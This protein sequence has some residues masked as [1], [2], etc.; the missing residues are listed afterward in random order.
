MTANEELPW[1]LT[2]PERVFSTL[3]RPNRYLALDF[4]TT[5]IDKGSA[6]NEL[7]DIVLACWAIVES[8]GTV[9]RKHIFGDQYSLRELEEDIR[10]T[11]FI[12]AHNA[13]FELQWLKRCGL[14]LRDV[15]VFDTMLAEWVIGGNRY[16]ISDLGLEASCL[17]YGLGTKLP[18]AGMMIK[19]G[20][21]PSTI[22]REWLLD[23]CYKDVEL[24]QMLYE[25]QREV[26]KD[27]RLFHL[28]LTRNLTCACLADI[29]FNGCELDRDKVLAEYEKA[30]EEFTKIEH[31]LADFAGDTN[32]SSSKQLAVL[33]Y[34]KLGF[35]PPLDPRTKEPIKT[36]GGKV[37]TDVA[38]L[39]KLTASTTD[40]RTFLDL[41]KRRNK[42]SALLTKTLE[43]CKGVVEEYDGKY[44][45]ILNQGFTDTHRLSSSGKPLKFKAHKKP[46]GI[47]LQ[48]FPRELKFLFT[49]HNP[50]YLIA[51]A[52]G[53]QLEFRVAAELGRDKVAY[54]EIIKGVDVHSITAKVL[55]EAGEPTT[56]QQAKAS[57][58]APLFGGMG[59]TK[60]VK[61][62]A[63]FF[64]KKYAGIAKTQKEWTLHVLNEGWLRTRFGMKFYWPG[65]R[66]GRSGYIDNTTSIYNYPIQSTATAEIIPIALVHFWHRTRNTRTVIWN[67]IHDS[68]GSRVH[69]DDKEEYE[70]LSVQSMTHDVYRFLEKFYNVRMRVPLGVGIKLED[71]KQEITYDVFSDG[72]FSRSVKE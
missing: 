17:R 64:K 31:S 41:Y 68:I 10:E 28:A 55:T 62:Y 9:T 54:E 25:K 38:T 51:E 8:D 32:L 19:A 61:E 18:L 50:D 34:E 5:S 52:D 43:F 58:F 15:L 46:K 63:E 66:Q 53:S 20:I 16:K 30:V 49:A 26:L 23:Y 33:L 27:E 65:T 44:M 21:C 13:K 60:A 70:R 12:V 1:F 2:D 14:E 59:K 67:T 24:C 29:E 6:L 40:Q 3:Y 45:G 4:E 36:K 56:R 35:S 72:R 48:N 11:D 57:T 39:D 37:A 42:L 69:K 7:N 22:P 47:Q 71:S